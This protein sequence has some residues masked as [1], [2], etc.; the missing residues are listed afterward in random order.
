[1]RDPTGD[2][3]RRRRETRRRF[4]FIFGGLVLAVTAIW[5]AVASFAVVWMKA[6][7]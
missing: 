1:M 2:W 4:M 7:P 5:I 3:E 6:A